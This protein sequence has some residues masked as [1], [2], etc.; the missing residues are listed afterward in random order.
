LRIP[1]NKYLRDALFKNMA[2]TIQEILTQFNRRFSHH[3]ETPTLDAQVLVAHF[4]DKPRSWVL[5]H[6]EAHIDEHQYIKIIQA[7]ERLDHGEP[8]PYIIGHWEFYGLDFTLTPDVLIPRPETELL[9]E[10]GITWMRNH[11]SQRKAIDVGTGSGCI[12]IALAMNIPDLRVLMT[13]IL[14]SALNL[15]Q[16]NAEKYGLS[17]MLVFQ[18]SNLLDGIAGQYDLI[19]ANLPY[20]PS[21]TLSKLPVVAWEPRLAL[22][23]GLSGTDLISRLLDQARSRLAPGGMM[24]L[25]IEASQGTEV[26]TIAGS[27]FPAAQVNILKDLSG[28]DRCIEITPSN[29]LIHLCQ[30]NEWQSAQKQGMVISKSIGH[31]GFIHCSQPEQILDVA[32]RFYQGIP[33]LILL[34]IDPKKITSEIRWEVVDGVL[35]PHIYGPINLD[36]VISVTDIKPDDD[37]TYRV[38]QLPD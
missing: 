25:E 20:I 28:F 24:L 29:L 33:G 14:P 37:G 22:D 26:R 23:G 7:L 13:D 15:A 5:A 8:L 11:Q 9:V 12:G 2:I 3:S 17:D 18:Q 34:W 19:C 32:N 31:E 36:A 16:V 6:P 10:Q 30:R 35:F 27:L 4:L 38:V 21:Q 1:Y